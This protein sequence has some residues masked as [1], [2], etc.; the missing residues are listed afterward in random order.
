MGSFQMSLSKVL[1]LTGAAVF[2]SSAAFAGPVPP[3]ASDVTGFHGVK[4]PKNGQSL[5]P[6]KS[7]LCGT[8]FGA[9]LPTP[10][11]LV[12]WNDTSGTTFNTGGAADF[13]CSAKAKIKQVWAYGYNA[14]A[15]PELYNVNIYQND[16]KDGSDEGKDA[17]KSVCSYTGLSGAGGGAYP[18]HVLTKL[19]LTTA[20]K[21]KPG[22]YWVEIQDNDSAG[23][24]YW[25][26]TSDLSGTQGDW[27]DRYN[28]YATGCTA[29]DND[30]YLSDCLGY[31]YPDYMLELH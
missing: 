12:S 2:V 6:K 19:T 22:K 20:C 8:G 11:G 16:T 10:D 24:W 17:K 1:L 30:E 27:V 5:A 28:A 29:L 21:V 4:A 3:R 18:T 7:A 26:M 25:E 31:T 15:N 14:P 9:E 23:P 13:T